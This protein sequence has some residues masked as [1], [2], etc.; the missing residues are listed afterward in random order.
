MATVVDSQA[1]KDIAGISARSLLGAFTV[2]N[3][4]VVD[5]S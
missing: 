5:R 2:D 1:D 4:P 3:K